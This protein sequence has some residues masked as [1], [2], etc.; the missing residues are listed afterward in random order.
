MPNIYYQKQWL[1]KK[2]E[3]IKEWEKNSFNGFLYF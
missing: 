3:D 2:K 1:E